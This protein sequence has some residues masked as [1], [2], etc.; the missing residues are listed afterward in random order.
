[1]FFALFISIQ[2]PANLLFSMPYILVFFVLESRQD[3]TVFRLDNNKDFQKKEIKQVV[4]KNNKLK[5]N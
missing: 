1:M 2:K 3:N 4:R 5:G